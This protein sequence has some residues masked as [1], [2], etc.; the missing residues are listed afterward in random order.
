MNVSQATKI[1]L[2]FIGIIFF[3]FLLQRKTGCKN[4]RAV[5]YKLNKENYCLL[6]ADN[7]AKWTKGLMNY[8]KPVDF[9]GM[10]FIFPKKEIQNF[11][12]MNTYLDLDLYWL[13]DQKIVGKSFLPSIE[14]TKDINYVSSPKPANKVIEIIK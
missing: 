7:S 14:R 4:N 9:D 2:F 1:L 5:V 8:K 3:F 12:N 13:D 11:W 10:I 6:V